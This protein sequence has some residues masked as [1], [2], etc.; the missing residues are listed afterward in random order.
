MSSSDNVKI[1]I[2]VRFFASDNFS[3]MLRTRNES[4]YLYGDKGVMDV[5]S[6][7]DSLSWSFSTTSPYE[8]ISMSLQAPMAQLSSIFPQGIYGAPTTGFWAVVNLLEPN[9]SSGKTLAWGRVETLSVSVSSDMGIG[10]VMG[11]ASLTASSWVNYLDDN[12]FFASEAKDFG[13][14]AKSVGGVVNEAATDSWDRAIISG[15]ELFSFCEGF[16]ATSDLKSQ[17]LASTKIADNG[18]GVGVSKFFHEFANKVK[19]PSSFEA[20]NEATTALFSEEK[21]LETPALRTNF[22]DIIRVLY[23]TKQAFSEYDEN[24]TETTVVD[25]ET[26]METTTVSFSVEDRSLIDL[27]RFG[28]HA[29]VPIGGSPNFLVRDFEGGVWSWV[30]RTFGIDPNVV[31][32]FPTLVEIDTADQFTKHPENLKQP[33]YAF[34]DNRDILPFPKFDSGNGNKS[35]MVPVILYRMKPIYDSGTS[36]PG[37]DIYE[38]NAQFQR[39][40]HP[41]LYL[42]VDF[43]CTNYP[44]FSPESISQRSTAKKHSIIKNASKL[45]SLNFSLSENTRTNVASVRQPAALSTRLQFGYGFSNIRRPV[46]DAA[47]ISD[48][49]I[50]RQEVTWNVIYTDSD[51]YKALTEYVYAVFYRQAMARGSFSCEFDPNIRAGMFISILI[52]DDVNKDTLAASVYVEEVNHS[53][54]IDSNGGYI[55]DTQVNFSSG[56]FGSSL[57]MYPLGDLEVFE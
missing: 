45:T 54:T 20:R 4:E 17:D 12:V 14:K 6:Y 57:G 29:S 11:E 16:K 38:H 53:V 13:K 37:F 23:A 33:L 42:G 21:V 52:D 30:T 9:G 10:T 27:S 36:Y 50:R 25:E 28:N 56:F 22:S 3:N 35:M 40:G 48:H 47:S 31:E 49:G 2:Q 43:S 41:D 15:D 1:P 46:F 8:T 32:L 34:E 44:H 39:A 26:G 51:V 24:R 5:S 18:L 19:L 7:V 55:A